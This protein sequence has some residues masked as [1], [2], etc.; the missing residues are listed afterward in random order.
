MHHPTKQPKVYLIDPSFEDW[1]YTY[2]V[3]FEQ[4]SKIR[5]LFKWL[6]IIKTCYV[7]LS[8]WISDIS[9][10]KHHSIL[11]TNHIWPIETTRDNI[12]MMRRYKN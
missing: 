10:Q 3:W 11:E 2:S 12:K 9:T 4:Q 8:E 7:S 5:K 6:D 1:L